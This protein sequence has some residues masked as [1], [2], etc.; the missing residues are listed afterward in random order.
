MCINVTLIRG[1]GIGS[2]VMSAAVK[3]IEKVCSDIKWEEKEAGYETFLIKGEPL[4]SD[5]VESIRKNKLAFK[6]PLTTPV[7]EGYRSVNVEL[8]KQLDLYANVR[9]VKTFKGIKSRYDNIDLVIVRENTEDLYCGIEHM[10]GASAAESIKIITEP[11]SRRIAEYAFNM[12]KDQER[13][14]VTVGHKANI[15]KLT[16]GLFMKTAEKVS[17]G[18]PQVEFSKEIIDALCMKLV[19]NPEKFDVLLLPNLY[20]DIVSD[21]AAGLVGGLGIAPSGNIGKDAAIFE[22]VHGS[23]PD[24]AGKNIANPVSAILAGAML[25]KHIGK[26]DEALKIEAAVACVLEEGTEVTPDLGGSGT[27]SGFGDA[28][29]KKL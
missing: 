14:K 3:V 11:G 29:I 7:G 19:M 27:T 5:T 16:D 22:P 18:F 4:S 2:E 25:L 24:I 12:A 28:V 26:L 13:K 23:A 20:G 15:M 17:A 9:P 10:V 21:L 6:G 1:D 8:R